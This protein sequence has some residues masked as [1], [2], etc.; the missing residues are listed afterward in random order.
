MT[1]M[2]ESQIQR[3]ITAWLKA[4]GFLVWKISDRYRSGIPDLYALRNGD[5]YWF[6]V[7]RPGGRVSKLQEHEIGQ[8]RNHGGLAFVVR[9]V[10]DV[11]GVVI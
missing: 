8:L 2:T 7:K 1:A 9:S 5:S 11:R 6:E 3:Q 4:A 10:D